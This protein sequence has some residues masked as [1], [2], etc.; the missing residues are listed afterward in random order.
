MLDFCVVPSNRWGIEMMLS[1]LLSVYIRNVFFLFFSPWIIPWLAGPYRH[2]RLLPSPLPR[3][4]P[5]WS[6]DR[7]ARQSETTDIRQKEK[8]EENLVVKLNRRKRLYI[9]QWLR[10]TA[11]ACL[12]MPR[13]LPSRSASSWP[14]RY[15]VT[16]FIHLF[17]FFLSNRSWYCVVLPLLSLPAANVGR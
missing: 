5:C 11:K 15:V 3:H 7:R 6:D 2:F 1:L 16:F 14:A 17:F 13:P 9:W 12:M 4:C 10:W 8:K